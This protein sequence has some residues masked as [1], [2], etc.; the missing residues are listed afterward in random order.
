MN[1]ARRWK[2]SAASPTACR[3]RKSPNAN[4]MRCTAVATSPS[5]SRRF[6]RIAR[7][8][9]HRRRNVVRK[10]PM[11]R[12][13]LPSSRRRQ[14]HR[15]CACAAGQSN[16][17]LNRAVDDGEPPEPIEQ[18]P[19]Q[20]AE[21]GTISPLS[22]GEGSTAAMLRS[23]RWRSTRSLASACAADGGQQS[24]AGHAQV[25]APS[26]ATQGR[27]TAR[28]E[29]SWRLHRREQRTGIGATR[30]GAIGA[31]SSA[32]PDHRRAHDGSPSVT[33]DAV[34]EARV[35]APASP[36]RGTSRSRNRI[37]RLAGTR[38]VSAGKGR[39]RRCLARAT[40]TPV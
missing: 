29:N 18:R 5:S 8:E 34:A 37:R 19:R 33:L 2:R 35:S 12:K 14:A 3:S 24:R 7:V 9:Q 4:A 6:A 25:T 23:M 20:R 17:A 26:Y 32:V 40:Q 11:T 36:D 30:T 1:N 10:L 13:S 28:P 38:A 31:R 21:T 27:T 39:R 15:R 22:S 16:L